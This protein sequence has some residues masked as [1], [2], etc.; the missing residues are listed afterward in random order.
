MESTSETDLLSRVIRVVAKSQHMDASAIKPE[1]TV[2]ELG[3]DSLDGLQILFALEEE[4]GVSIPD[5][6]GKEFNSIA[7]VSGGIQMLLKAK[8][9]PAPAS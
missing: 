3:I 4:F 7:R 6:A 2:A 9:E 8:S 5:D 1:S